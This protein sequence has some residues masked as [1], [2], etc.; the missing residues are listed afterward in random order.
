MDNTAS[1]LRPYVQT[2]DNISAGRSRP[3]SKPADNRELLYSN[4]LNYNRQEDI[5]DDIS[6]ERLLDI[7]K[8]RN[9]FDK[10]TVLGM[11]LKHAL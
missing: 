7:Y 9:K 3:F 10:L 5:T 1:N 8:C 6:N 11:M 2:D 4:V